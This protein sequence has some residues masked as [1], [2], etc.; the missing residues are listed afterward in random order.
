MAHNCQQLNSSSFPEESCTSTRDKAAIE[1]TP[2]RDSVERH[3]FCVLVQL[4]HVKQISYHYQCN[5]PGH[6]NHASVFACSPR[7][8]N[9]IISTTAAA[10][11]MGMG[12]HCLQVE[13]IVPRCLLVLLA[14]F[15]T[16]IRIIAV[17]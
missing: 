10:T 16:A 15:T 2:R 8:F 12:S 1:G 17:V 13:L 5:N 6:F 3:E 4:L 14:V 11:Q 7:L 9:I